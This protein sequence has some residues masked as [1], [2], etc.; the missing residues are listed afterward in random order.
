MLQHICEQTHDPLAFWPAVF[1]RKQYC[2]AIRHIACQCSDNIYVNIQQML[3]RTFETWRH[4]QERINCFIQEV[5][6]KIRYACKHISIMVPW[7]LFKEIGKQCRLLLLLVIKFA[8]SVLVRKD[9]EKCWFI[10]GL[11]VTWMKW[12]VTQRWRWRTAVVRIWAVRRW[13]VIIRWR[14]NFSKGSSRTRCLKTK[15]KD[16]WKNV[17]PIWMYPIK[18][19]KFYHHIKSATRGRC[20]DINWVKL[21]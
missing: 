15:W 5:K 13:T 10:W 6:N 11:C 1:E 7:N 4:A 8:K 19:C 18:R 16:E 12:W 20:S 9:N 21:A 14:I 2:T 3:I 17:R